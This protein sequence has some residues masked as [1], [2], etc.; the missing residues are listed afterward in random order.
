M[1]KRKGVIL[2]VVVIVIAV[3]L[4][5]ASAYLAA[6]AAAKRSMAK[7]LSLSESGDYAGALPY[8]E[9]A[10]RYSFGR[11]AEVTAALAE[12]YEMLGQK[13][14]AKEAYK[15]VLSLDSGNAEARYRLGTIYIGEKNFG[16]AKTEIE[17]LEKL[18]TEESLRYA[19]ILKDE[20]RA[21]SVKNLFNE[22]VQKVLP[23]FMDGRDK[24]TS[25]DAE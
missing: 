9:K 25:G 21:G 16:A 18:G 8:F 4:T 24:R 11:D 22:I 15:K 17:E 23:G 19:E 13:D 1:K 12:T 7:G 20:S 2:T 10:D 6:C 5:A 3:A 14:A